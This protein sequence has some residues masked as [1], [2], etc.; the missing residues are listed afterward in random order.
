MTT[1]RPAKP[2]EIMRP[3]GVIR[4]P[5]ADPGDTPLQS[6][7]GAQVEGRI[8]VHESFVDGLDGLDGFDFAHVITLLD[9]ARGD[10]DLRPEPLLLRGTGRRVGV[11]ATR[12]PAR[13][14][15]LGLS[16]IR[17][18]RIDGNEITFR[19]VDTVDGTPVLDIKPWVPDFDLPAEARERADRGRI[20]CGWYTQFGVLPHQEDAAV[21][22]GIVASRPGDIA[23]PTVLIGGAVSRP[24]R[25]TIR[26]LRRLRDATVTVDFARRG[27]VARR[28]ICA[29]AWLV[30]V[31]HL[32]GVRVGAEDR[33]DHLRRCVVV[34]ASDGRQVTFSLGELDRAVGSAQVLLTW[35]IDENDL[36]AFRLIVGSDAEGVRSLSRLSRIDVVDPGP[37]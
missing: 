9:G 13:P 29:G 1:A 7:L 23:G 28:R 37:K 5:F 22:A 30:D 18:L 15:R 6:F 10:G 21:D 27:Q 17:I 24:G 20:R 16:L 3:I 34:T 19:G 11:F 14:N 26:S 12:Y 35:R 36:D 31:L 33:F 32:V 8:V 25:L 4:S 2:P